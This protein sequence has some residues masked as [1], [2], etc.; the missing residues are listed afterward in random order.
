MSGEPLDQLINTVDPEACRLIKLPDKIWVFGGACEDNSANASKSLRNSF[1]RQTM[2]PA[3]FR[4]WLEHLK[5][6]E[7]YPEWLAFSGYDDLLEFERDACYLAHATILFAESPGSYAEL[8][9]LALDKWILPQ[10]FVVVQSDNFRGDRRNSFLNLGPLARVNTT[11]GRCVIST[12]STRELP[13]T[14]FDS[15]IE[16]IDHWL[17]KKHCSSILDIHNP[18]HRLMLLA[19]LVD[20]LLVSTILEIQRALTY[21]KVQMDE[22]EI[23]KSLILLDFFELVKFENF[24]YADFCARRK[25]S[26]APWI[27]YTAKEEC[28]KFDRS[29]FKVLS[30]KHVQGN[31]RKKSIFERR[32]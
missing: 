20:L 3:I 17:P 8:G 10:L 14:D 24:G 4:P 19:D 31:G 32:Q 7:D 28:G 26:S 16:S 25:L 22:S 23:K 12:D 13:E 11:K 21:F 15:I 2:S 30:E 29:R 6:P 1:W 9:A 18:M 5:R 27:D